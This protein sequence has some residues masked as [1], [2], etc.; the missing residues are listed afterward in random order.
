MA[1]MV[2]VFQEFSDMQLLVQLPSSWNFLHSIFCF[3]KKLHWMYCDYFDTSIHLMNTDVFCAFCFQ[4][5]IGTNQWRSAWLCDRKD[6]LC[7]VRR[8]SF[9]LHSKTTC[10]GSCTYTLIFRMTLWMSQRESASKCM[11]LFNDT[12]I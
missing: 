2:Q 8:V 3:I 12:G 9:Y 5:A 6:A 10:T 7:C 11:L 1:R 4:R